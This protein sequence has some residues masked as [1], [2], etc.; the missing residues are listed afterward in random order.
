MSDVM[1]AFGQNLVRIRLEQGMSRKELS[2]L[3]GIS[4]IT[5]E[6]IESGNCDVDTGQVYKIAKI[7]QVGLEDLFCSDTS[8]NKLIE[9]IKLNLELCSEADL[10]LVFEY[11][12][13]L[14]KN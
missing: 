10:I 13:S 1:K 12:N 3:L 8:K 11:M 14:I 5:L 2:A 6:G 7:L 4:E 9:Q